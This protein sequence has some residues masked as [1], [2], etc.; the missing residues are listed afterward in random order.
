MGINIPKATDAGLGKVKSE[1]VNVS[2]N[3]DAGAILP[4]RNSTI[5]QLGRVGEAGVDASG[6]LAA[7]VV[8]QKRIHDDSVS[9]NE[10][11]NASKE[12]NEYQA[13][14]L[15]RKGANAIGS[16]KE[17]QIKGN[18]IYSK[19]AANLQ[20]DNQRGLFS[21]KWGNE[22]LS[23]GEAISRF[24]ANQRSA[25]NIESEKAF[26]QQ[27]VN[28]ALLNYTDPKQVKNAEAN[29]ISET[30]KNIEGLSS[31]ALQLR[32]Q[33]RLSTLRE[34]LIDRLST[35]APYKAK[36]L[37]DA[38]QAVLTPEDRTKAENSLKQGA[39]VAFYSMLEKDPVKA[40]EMLDKG[41]FGNVV[42]PE[43]KEKYR[44]SIYR[45]VE[46]MANRA[47]VNQF[48]ST[49]KN[50]NQLFDSM[51]QSNR[52]DAFKKLYDY[53]KGFN[54]DPAFVEKTREILLKTKGPNFQEKQDAITD[55][56]NTFNTFELK[57]KDGEYEVSS[58]TDFRKLIEFNRQIELN[59]LAGNIDKGM[60]NSYRK[61]ISPAMAEVARKEKGYDDIGLGDGS[62]DYDSGTQAINDYLLRNKRD[63]DVV[64]KSRMMSRYI[65]LQD[66]IPQ[67]IKNDPVQFNNKQNELIKFVIDEDAQAKNP[68]FR[69]LGG[70]P[71][72]VIK[73][74]GTVDSIKSTPSTVKPASKV[75]ED[76]TVMRSKSTGQLWR[77]YKDGRK[78]PAPEQPAPANQ[79]QS[80]NQSFGNFFISDAAAADNPQGEVL[81][82][83]QE[84]KLGGLVLPT[85]MPKNL[86]GLQVDGTINL[87]QRPPSKVSIIEDEGKYF[88]I[89]LKDEDG[90]DLTE[91]K[92]ERQFVRTDRHFGAFDSK[93]SAEQYQKKLLAKND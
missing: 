56:E 28:N 73:S 3:I 80:S 34:G 63:K 25:Y 77:V 82:P 53:Q 4:T 79:Q 64:T 76:F 90:K 21:Q 41:F 50:E 58:K 33:G 27:N 66:Q 72:S 78:E 16:Y 17:S 71:N 81:K 67:E 88:I 8:Q 54:A 32:L 11:I 20:D 48:L 6:V 29:I 1:A 89:P 92:A 15:N 18:E 44:S 9:N 10:F 30:N 60:A 74:D 51:A 19:Y 36:Q 45:Q 47:Q 83:G 12:Y 91:K 49:M 61:R 69:T 13:E 2:Q 65:E 52:E 59:Y 23:R 68:I 31:D 14:L 70:V 24:E 7:R 5:V 85:P 40:Q 87:V 42:D 39:D 26:V 37:F 35:T 55:L 93:E 57:K 22:M 46:N 38:S 86:P 43:R 62:E 75:D 84:K